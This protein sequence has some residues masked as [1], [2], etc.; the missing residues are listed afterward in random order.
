MRIPLPSS[1]PFTHPARIGL[2]YLGRAKNLEQRLEAMKLVAAAK[3]PSRQ[4]PIDC[5]D[6]AKRV[7]RQIGRAR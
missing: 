4:F 6:D 5:T 1:C 7:P 2:L 3:V